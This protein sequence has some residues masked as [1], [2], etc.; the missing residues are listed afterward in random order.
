M[1]LTHNFQPTEEIVMNE[2]N[3]THVVLQHTY[4]VEFLGGNIRG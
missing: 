4:L 1:H 2:Y 3:A